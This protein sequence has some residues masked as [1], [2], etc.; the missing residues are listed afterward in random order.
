MNVKVQ[1]SMYGETRKHK[2]FYT[3]LF[4]IGS[5]QNTQDTA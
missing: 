4:P 1:F 3:Q 2:E 5:T